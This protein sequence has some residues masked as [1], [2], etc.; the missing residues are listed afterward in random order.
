VSTK[1]DKGIVV[2]L[3]PRVLT[4]NYGSAFLRALPKCL[5]EVVGGGSVKMWSL[6]AME[7]QV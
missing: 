7:R 6:A 2:I 3:D 5:V 4:K 1:Q